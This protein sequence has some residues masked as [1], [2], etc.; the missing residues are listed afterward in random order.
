MF[1]IDKEIIIIVIHKKMDVYITYDK[2]SK[3]GCVFSINKNVN[4]FVKKYKECNREYVNIKDEDIVKKVKEI[5]SDLIFSINDVALDTNI[6]CCKTNV[7]IDT[8]KLYFLICD[9]IGSGQSYEPCY[10]YWGKDEKDIF[11]SALMFFE[12]EKCDLEDENKDDFLKE[13]KEEGETSF[14]CA[15]YEE[16]IVTLNSMKISSKEKRH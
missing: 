3:F 2:D 6:Y 10:L 4:Y 16:C 12:D 14:E 5:D 9:Q 11:K 15:Y 1:Q 7:P 8:K 13:L